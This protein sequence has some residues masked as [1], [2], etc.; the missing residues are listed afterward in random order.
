ML[1]NNDSPIFELSMCSL[2]NFHSSFLCWLGNNYKKEFLNL[3]KEELNNDIDFDKYSDESIEIKTQASDKGCKFDLQIKFIN[4]NKIEHCIIIENKLKS[5][6]NDEQ[7]TKYF[8]IINKQKGNTNYIFILL[9]LMKIPLSGKNKDKWKNISYSDLAKKMEN[10][11]FYYGKNNDNKDITRYHECLIKDYIFVIKTISN[12][13][14]KTINNSFRNKY[15]FYKE[16]E[17]KKSELVNIGLRDIYVKFRTSELANYIRKKIDKNSDWK[18]M[19]SF[20]SKDKKGV[21]DIIIQLKDPNIKFII[22]IQGTQYRYGFV[23]LEKKFNKEIK[24]KREELA[25]KLKSYWFYDTKNPNKPRIYDGFYG[26]KPD[27]IY[28]KI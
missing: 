4:G 7:L 28:I 22:S 23:Y 8:D 17:N 2:E 10:Q 13:F 18:V 5:F 25:K 27:F 16:D 21:V 1:K 9:S 20:S 15:N 24:V 3:F 6:P 12:V 11:D 19:Y 14:S 26:Y